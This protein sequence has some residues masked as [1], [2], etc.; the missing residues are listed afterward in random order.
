MAQIEKRSQ[1]I[2]KT[3]LRDNPEGSPT[4]KASL[5]DLYESEQTVD[6]IPTEELKIQHEDEKNKE[7]TK[8]TSSS[9]KRYPG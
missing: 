5:L 6:P 8:N 7:T 9:E 1:E 2:V 4:E 3:N